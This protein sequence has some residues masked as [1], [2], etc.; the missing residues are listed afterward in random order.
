MTKSSPFPKLHVLDISRNAFIG[1]LPDEYLKHFRAM[2]DI[3]EN[4]T[5]D[6][7]SWLPNY[8][9]SSF[10]LKGLDQS[11]ERL[12]TAFT[13]IDLS[14]NLFSGNIPNSIGNLQSLVHLNLSQ[15]N[16]T[17]HI[18]PSLGNMSALESLD[19]SSNKLDGEIP[20]ELTKFT[21][22]SKLNLSM[23]NLVGQIPHST[24]FSTFENDSYMGNSRLCGFPLTRKC[25]GENRPNLVVPEEEEEEGDDQS[26][27]V[28]GFGWQV[29]A[30]GYGCGF[31]VGATLDRANPI[32]LVA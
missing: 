8:I 4:V 27:F 6:E 15:N 18:P 10:T 28:N 30:L 24:Q 12:L 2:M 25:G 29:V 17:G 32:N 7:I 21:F 5:E 20:S 9:E 1:S 11:L 23:N 16:L 14:S 26:D 31:V 3:V 19:L 13:T 22:L